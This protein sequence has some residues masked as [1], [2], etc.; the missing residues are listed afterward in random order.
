MPGPPPAGGAVVGGVLLPPKVHFWVVPPA[1]AQSCSLAP[2]A[3]FR[4]L[5]S[6]H[7]PVA[8]LTRS[9]AAFSDHFWEA[10]ESKQ[11]Q[12]CTPAPSAVEFFTTSRHLPLIWIE[13]L[14]AS[15]QTWFAEPATQD[16]SCGWVPFAVAP[17]VRSRHLLLSELT[18]VP[19]LAADALVTPRTPRPPTTSAPVSTARMRL[20]FMPEPPTSGWRHRCRSRS[21]AWCRSLSCCP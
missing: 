20:R 10:T 2:S 3:V 8:V 15:V 6:R 14:S 11:S 19:A 4:S 17:P 5:T 18:R 16:H 9:F 7:F 21:G 1:H 13:P 12:T